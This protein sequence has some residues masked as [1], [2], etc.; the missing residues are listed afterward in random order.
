LRTTKSRTWTNALYPLE[1]N[2]WCVNVLEA[3]HLVR[4]EI[5]MSYAL[6][7]LAACR[8]VYDDTD[9]DD[10][11]D[12]NN[13]NNNMPTRYNYVARNLVR[14]ITD[15]SRTI[16]W[17]LTVKKK[18]LPRIN[19]LRS[20]SCV[21]LFIMLVVGIDWYNVTLL[22][23]YNR[24]RLMQYNII[25][26]SVFGVARCRTHREPLVRRSVDLTRREIPNSIWSICLDR[27][28]TG[29]SL[30]LNTI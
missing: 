18:T 30:A 24:K 25:I 14:T 15:Y 3:I 16:A 2:T 23:Q 9:D 12:N 22:Q 8:Q 27:A 6:P 11:D 4:L 26:Y 1:E 7:G 13:N 21:L 20:P 17:M 5:W 29:V 28:H 10:N 19:V